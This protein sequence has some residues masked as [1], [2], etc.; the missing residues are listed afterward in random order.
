MCVCVVCDNVEQIGH[1]QGMVANRIHSSSWFV[2]VTPARVW[3]RV[4]GSAWHLRLLW[5][6]IVLAIVK[7]A[8]S[9][10]CV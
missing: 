7:Q 8:R 9:A 6:R 2:P 10:K 1:Q 4:V 5:S 3:H